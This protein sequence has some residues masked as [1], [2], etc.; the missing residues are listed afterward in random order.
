MPPPAPTLTADELDCLLWGKEGAGGLPPMA[1][2]PLSACAPDTPG[3]QPPQGCAPAARASRPGEKRLPEGRLQEIAST[4]AKRACAA[5]PAVLEAEGWSAG[6]LIG[7]AVALQ[8]AQ[9]AAEAA[10]AAAVT[11]ASST[12]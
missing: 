2:L 6:R 9:E 1:S 8:A 10:A 12:A 4:V 3:A 7:Y 5:G 11:T